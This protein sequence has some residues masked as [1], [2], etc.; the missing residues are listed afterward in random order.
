MKR[1]VSTAISVAALVTV[2]M[3]GIGGA[4]H[5]PVECSGV[6]ASGAS[7]QCIKTFNLSVDDGRRFV[8]EFQSHGSFHNAPGPMGLV[9]LTWRDASNGGGEAGK[10]VA[11]FTCRAIALTQDGYSDYVLTR[12]VTCSRSASGNT[13]E[14]V[15]GRQTLYVDVLEA[16]GCPTSGCNFHGRLWLAGPGEI[17]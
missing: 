8:S 1:L 17:Y 9:K 13:F 4:A 5:R 15:A 10:V 14:Y 11:E 16:T 12:T 3:P 7:A 6:V 2:L